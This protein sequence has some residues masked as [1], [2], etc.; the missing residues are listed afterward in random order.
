MILTSIMME[1]SNSLNFGLNLD[2][3]CLKLDLFWIKS[4]SLVIQGSKPVPCRQFWI[5]KYVQGKWTNG[6]VD[7]DSPPSGPSNI[8]VKLWLIPSVI[9]H[10]LC[11]LEKQVRHLSETIQIAITGNNSAS[12][13][14]P[15]KHLT[16]PGHKISMQR[17][18][19]FHSHRYACENL[20][21]KAD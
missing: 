8:W 9:I 7:A 5:L 10:Q 2:L 16:C 15:H 12:Q 6:C 4:D 21:L 19:P 1:Y 20:N 13:A 18:I 3:N 11:T 17:G 14:V